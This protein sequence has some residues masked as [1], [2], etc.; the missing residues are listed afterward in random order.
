ML[1]L[2]RKQELRLIDIGLA[3][4]IDKLLVVKPEK[5]SGRGGKKWSPEQKRKFKATM[6]KKYGK[7]FPT[8]E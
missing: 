5:K 3:T 8:S 6:K 7:R 1:K 2:T 4:V